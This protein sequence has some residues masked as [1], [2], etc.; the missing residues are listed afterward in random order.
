MGSESIVLKSVSAQSIEPNTALFDDFNVNTLNISIWE[1]VKYGVMSWAPYEI[2]DGRLTLFGTPSPQQ[3]STWL[4]HRYSPPKGGFIVSTRVRGKSLLLA[5][6]GIYSNYDGTYQGVMDD[7][8]RITLE[9][10]GLG[11]GF[12]LA[13]S[14][15]GVWTYPRTPFSPTTGKW[16]LLQFV[17][18]DNP[19]KITANIYDDDTS[20]FLGSLVTSDMDINYSS[21]NA[22]GIGV[23]GGG[24]ASDPFSEYD[25][26]WFKVENLDLDVSSNLTTIAFESL[27]T[28]VGTL[29]GYTIGENLS[30]QYQN[31]GVIFSI[32]ERGIVY[33]STTDIVHGYS[34][35]SGNPVI[36][37]N[38]VEE[39]QFSKGPSTTLSIFFVD[40]TTHIATSAINVKLQI[41]DYRESSVI[42]KTYDINGKLI[43][44][45]DNIFSVPKFVTIPYSVNAYFSGEISRIELIDGPTPD[46]F[47]FDDLTFELS[48]TS[49][50]V[51]INQ[52]YVSGI[53]V[54]VGSVQTA[55]FQAT[56]SL[57]GSE[58]IGGDIYVN[59][60]RYTTNSSGWIVFD[61]SL[62][63]VGK[64]TWVITSIDCNGVTDFQSLVS[65]PT[66]IWDSLKIDEVKVNA[67]IP[68]IVQIIF[69]VKYEYDDS[70]INYAIATVNGIAAENIGNGKYSTSL[71]SLMPIFSFNINVEYNGFES[72]IT[73]MTSYSLGN[74]AVE[75]ISI[76]ALAVFAIRIKGRKHRMNLNKLKQTLLEKG[77]V[78]VTAFSNLFGNDEAVIRKMLSEIVNKK[79]IQGIFTLDKRIF[80][81]EA[82]LMEEVRRG[83]ERE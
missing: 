38:T 13:R 83:F 41:G 51:V 63:T 4:I 35:V 25:F 81:T 3:S 48:S 58:I 29:Y 61:D 30:N 9:M 42:V 20:A 31:K 57:N 15:N 62:S 68:V 14:V 6:L 1:N 2:K 16:Y 65:H 54:D 72:I 12:R 67:S 10:W 78:D 7:S 34:G 76:T 39:G 28:N 37:V 69:D 47:T 40:P 5:T 24:I 46:G 55:G 66:I 77:M 22:V 64:K 49:V 79:E 82:R 33:A 52:V 50:E 21:I 60:T 26:D 44:S 32:D 53:R 73:G 80:Y 56:W 43:E 59:D 36:A 27:N 70:P 71:T 74:I 75:G 23:L 17:V 11:M 8:G 19:F 18:E 45:F